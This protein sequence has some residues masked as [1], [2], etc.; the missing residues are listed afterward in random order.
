[1]HEDFLMWLPLLAWAACSGQQPARARSRLAPFLV[2][3]GTYLG[4]YLWVR[5]QGV[6]TGRVYSGTELAPALKSSVEA[7]WRYSISSL[8]PLRI[9]SRMFPFAATA[10]PL[11]AAEAG[12]RLAAQLGPGG[13]TA[14]AGTALLAVRLWWVAPPRRIKF[15]LGLGAAML[16]LP[17]LPIALTG[18]YQA[19]AHLH[20]FPYYY[21]S[22]GLTWVALSLA[23]AATAGRPQALGRRILLG[24]ALALG[25]FWSSATAISL[26]YEALA[27]FSRQSYG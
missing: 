22:L 7:L 10:A 5:H 1:M 19:W 8:S 4:L 9:F 13:W 18:R 15:P 6:A 2:I 17:N 27:D 12:R 3:A 24:L 26:T 23:A 21:S 20:R 14:A 16:F 25:L 11:S